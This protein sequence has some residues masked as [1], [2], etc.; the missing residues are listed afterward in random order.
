MTFCL[1]D[2]NFIRV[3]MHGFLQD[4]VRFVRKGQQYL[5][6]LPQHISGE[7]YWKHIAL[8]TSSVSRSQYINT[9]T[10]TQ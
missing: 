2:D 4:D 3:R 10:S 7:G 1:Y 9:D 5:T 6:I 8:I